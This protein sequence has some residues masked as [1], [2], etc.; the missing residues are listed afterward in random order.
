MRAMTFSRIGAGATLATVILTAWL[1]ACSSDNES[2]GAAG[3][4][5]TGTCE[6]G[7]TCPSG[8]VEIMIA[9]PAD[10]CPATNSATQSYICCGP[11][12]S[13]GTGAT[14]TTTGNVD[15]GSSTTKTTT[16]TADGSA[17]ATATTDAG[18]TKG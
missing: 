6:Q 17:S 9:D 12:G 2:C 5:K 3:M 11:M 16:T 10:Q 7:T 1:G 14:T 18:A 13:S 8:M 4:P 15:G